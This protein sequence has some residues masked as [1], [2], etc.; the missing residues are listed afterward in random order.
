MEYQ[1]TVG[2]EAFRIRLFELD[3]VLH[4]SHAGETHPLRAETPLRARIHTVKLGDRTI[5]F[6]YHR[7]KSGSV[8]VLDGALYHAEIREF[9]HVRFG[10][11]AK[12]PPGRA[13][14]DIRA[15]MPGVVVAVRVQPGDAV[16]K[17]QSLLSLHAMK[18][19]ND[20]RSPRDGVVLEVAVKP[21]QTVEKG[22]LMVR[23]GPLPE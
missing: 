3:G 1:V 5:R 19:E 16:K 2:G 8:I 11:I 15:P 23:L 22:T 7:E 4:V 9:A 18:L 12:R 6:G 13:R 21:E 14:T 10:G 20:I 17:D